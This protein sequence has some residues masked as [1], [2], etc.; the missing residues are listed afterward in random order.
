MG[1]RRG[2]IRLNDLE[3]RPSEDSNTTTF[4]DAVL[5]DIT[6]FLDKGSTSRG[7]FEEC[8]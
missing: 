6:S 5:I 1:Q 8:E 7:D 4:P 2:Q 3:R